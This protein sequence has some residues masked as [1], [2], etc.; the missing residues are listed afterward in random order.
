MGM[1]HSLGDMIAAVRTFNRF[2]SRVIG[3]F[4]EGLLKTSY[5]LTEARV[6]F[7]LAQRDTTEA[8]QLRRTLGLDAAYLSRMLQRF[9]TDGLVMRTRSDRDGRRQVLALTPSG[10]AAFQLLDGR[11]SADAQGLLAPLRDADRR[12]LVAAMGTIERLLSGNT[13]QRSITLRGM[14]P[15][16]LGWVVERHGA[17]Y[18]DSSAGTRPSRRSWRAS[19]PTTARPRPG[20]RGGLDRRRRR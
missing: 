12:E 4:G 5:S 10:R 1:D 14:R 20:T 16:D 8:V 2:Y 13:A 17:I 9:E 11:S 6:I 7:E 18:A 3:L 15:G 19:W